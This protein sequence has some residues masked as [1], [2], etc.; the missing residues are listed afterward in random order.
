[1]SFTLLNIIAAFCLIPSGREGM[2]AIEAVKDAQL[3]CQKYYLS[4][5]KSKSPPP[6]DSGQVFAQCVSEKSL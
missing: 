1:M 6:E 4:C 5:V 2:G 3:R